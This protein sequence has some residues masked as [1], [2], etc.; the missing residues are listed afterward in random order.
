MGADTQFTHGGCIYVN[1]KL[2]GISPIS[3]HSTLVLLL[4]L[5]QVS[6][7]V[8]DEVSCVLPFL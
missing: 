2:D 7:V 6:E 3:C 8:Y 4:H 5:P 1:C